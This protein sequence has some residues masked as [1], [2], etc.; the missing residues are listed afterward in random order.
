[1]TARDASGAKVSL[2]TLPLVAYALK[3][4]QLGRDY[5]LVKG[6]LVFCQAC[7]RSCRVARILAQ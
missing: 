7:Q 1:V 6:D 4:G 2:A 3:C 5:A